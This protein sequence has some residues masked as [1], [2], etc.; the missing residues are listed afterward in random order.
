MIVR[1]QPPG[2]RLKVIPTRLPQPLGKVFQQAI[3]PD[4]E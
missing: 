3:V 2:A 1:L 4:E